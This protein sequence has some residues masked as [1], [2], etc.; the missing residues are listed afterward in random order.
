MVAVIPVSTGM[1]D[2]LQADTPPR[3]VTSYPVQYSLLASV[4]HEMSTG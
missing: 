1:V 2:H 4:E 3:Y